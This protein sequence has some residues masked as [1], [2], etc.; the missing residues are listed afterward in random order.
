MCAEPSSSMTFLQLS[1]EVVRQSKMLLADAKLNLNLA[2]RDILRSYPWS[3]TCPVKTLALVAAAATTALPDDFAELIEWPSYP[4]FTGSNRIVR[5]VTS[6]EIL[7]RFARSSAT[8][9][10]RIFALEPAAFTILTGQRWLLRWWPTPSTSRTLSYR[11]RIIAALM[12]ADADYPIGGPMHN[13]TLIEGALAQWEKG[14]GHTV[15]VH[16]ALFQQEFAKSVAFE[17]RLSAGESLGVL[18]GGRF[19]HRHREFE[20]GALTEN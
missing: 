14:V 9:D 3:F 11:Y 4:A 19:R 7:D 8:S 10:P 5:K 17:Q 18:S 2:Q 15:G 6:K 1:N 20:L 16:Q 12:V 13:T